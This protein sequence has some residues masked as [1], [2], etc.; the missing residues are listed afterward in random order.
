M[1]RSM[2]WER[3]VNSAARLL[4]LWATLDPS[5]GLVHGALMALMALDFEGVKVLG[6]GKRGELKEEDERVNRVVGESIFII[7][8]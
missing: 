1:T 7:Q 6:F 8:K 5:L 3:E 4:S 2:G